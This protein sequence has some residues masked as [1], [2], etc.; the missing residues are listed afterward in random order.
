MLNVSFMFMCLLMQL[1]ML[2]HSCL[3]F[4]AFILTL[5]KNELKSLIYI[6]HCLSSA[7]A[8]TIQDAQNLHCVDAAASDAENF[9]SDAWLASFIFFEIF[10]SKIFG[11]TLQDVYN[12]PHTF[13]IVIQLYKT[14]SLF[15][16]LKS[17]ANRECSS[18]VVVIGY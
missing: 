16:S 1:L 7:N 14:N 4:A 13:Y 9:V 5:E 12:M 10:C 2:I 18:K 11:T 8:I 3:K 15:M 6:Q 17:V